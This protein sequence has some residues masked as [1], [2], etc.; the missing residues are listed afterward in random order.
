MT[1]VDNPQLGDKLAEV[2]C[3][4]AGQFRQADTVLGLLDILNRL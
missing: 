2:A 3:Q 1:L 4:T